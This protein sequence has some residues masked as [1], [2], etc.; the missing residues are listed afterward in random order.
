MPWFP[1]KVPFG[2]SRQ[3]CAVISDGLILECYID[4]LNKRPG[5]QA[6]AD[7]WAILLPEEFDSDMDWTY[8]YLMYEWDG[9]FS[10]MDYA[11]DFS[12]ITDGMTETPVAATWDMPEDFITSSINGPPRLSKVN[13][14]EKSLDDDEEVI[15]FENFKLFFDNG[16]ETESLQMH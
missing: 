10:R 1:G 12:L 6:Y 4:V 5:E 16:V 8:E 14:T 13:F 3:T 11:S 2:D 15:H 9:S 7:D